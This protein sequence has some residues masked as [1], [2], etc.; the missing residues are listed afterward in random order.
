[1]VPGVMSMVTRLS[2]SLYSTTEML[3]KMPSGSGIAR[4]ASAIS[5]RR[6]CG[7]RRR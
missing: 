3:P 1:M 6:G 4:R 5:V 7:C 2:V